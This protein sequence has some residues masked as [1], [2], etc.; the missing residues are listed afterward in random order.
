MAEI[1]LGSKDIFPD[2]AVLKSTL[3]KSYTY[4]KKLEAL[5]K[6]F[7]HEWK[8]Y[9]KKS[10]WV[11]KVMDK[12]KALFWITPLN[13]NFN[14]GFAVRECEKDTLIAGNISKG[15]KEKLSNAEK[16]PEGYAVRLNIGN[17]DDFEEI[18]QALK[19]LMDLRK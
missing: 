1:V 2:E 9:N 16:Y 11:F 13:G 7:S 3:A 18:A 14:I 17:K 8:F 5:T 4:Y 6:G 10:G 12:K 19:I 15:M